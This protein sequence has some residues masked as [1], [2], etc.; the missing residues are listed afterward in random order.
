M[1]YFL[2]VTLLFAVLAA[3]LAAQESTQT[4]TVGELS[5][6]LP[7]DWVYTD[8]GTGAVFAPDQHSI[9]LLGEA[10]GQV[11]NQILTTLE[12]GETQPTP[13]PVPVEPFAAG[14]INLYPRS[15]AE[16]LGF[17]PEN[18]LADPE[19]K[20]IEVE[21]NGRRGVEVP[22]EMKDTAPYLSDGTMAVVDYDTHILLWISYFVAEEDLRP[23]FLA[24]MRSVQV[25][26]TPAAPGEL[27]TVIEGAAAA[28]PILR[29][30]SVESARELGDIQTMIISPDAAKLAWLD[31]EGMCIYTF[32]T[33]A[34]ACTPYPEN[35]DAPPHMLRWSPDSQYITFYESLYIQANESDIWLF[36]TASQ[37]YLNRTDDN[38]VGRFFSEPDALLDYL[39]F[40]ADGTLYFFRTLLNREDDSNPTYLYRFPSLLEGEPELV[41]DLT[42]LSAEPFVHYEMPRDTLAGGAAVSPDGEWLAVL[43]RERRLENQ[44]IWLLNLKDGT[45]Q[46]IAEKDVFRGVGLPEWVELDALTL[47]GIDWLADQSGLLLSFASAARVGSPFTVYQLDLTTLRAEPLV[48]FSTVTSEQAMFTEDEQGVTPQS[49]LPHLSAMLPDKSATLLFNNMQGAMNLYMVTPGSA[50]VLIASQEVATLGETPTTIGQDGTLIRVLFAGNIIT[51]EVEP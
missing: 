4:V 46:V 21:I 44:A 31:R 41:A 35:F 22:L 1:R 34:T 40:W 9:D 19:N 37:T 27:P 18:L 39:P 33:L 13:T 5:F 20:A 26:G 25:G 47:N 28:S 43:G 12:S 49:R 45:A 42:A 16:T 50:P 51:L 10:M 7:A 30:V 32:A 17:L 6:E 8:A 2:L 24:I 36:D 29:V 3:P 15:E 48:D 23:V 14:L 38:I 11:F